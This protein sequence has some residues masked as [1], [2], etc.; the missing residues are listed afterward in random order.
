MTQSRFETGDPR[1][2][3][4]NG[5][6]AVAEGRVMH[7]TVNYQMEC[8]L[9]AYAPPPHSRERFFLVDLGDWF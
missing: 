7:S 1:Y 4:L 8:E 2:K 9:S 3:W 6:M 5:V